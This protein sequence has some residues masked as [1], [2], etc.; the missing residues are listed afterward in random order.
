[1]DKQTS[2]RFDLIDPQPQ[3]SFDLYLKLLEIL[4]F[5]SSLVKTIHC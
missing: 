2:T 5:V 1:M 3:S 4:K